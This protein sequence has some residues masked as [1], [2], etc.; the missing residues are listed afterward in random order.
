MV[1]LVTKRLT[2]HA[3]GANSLK[4]AWLLVLLRVAKTFVPPELLLAS[5]LPFLPPLKRLARERLYQCLH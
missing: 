2:T 3:H 1:K 4:L 5:K